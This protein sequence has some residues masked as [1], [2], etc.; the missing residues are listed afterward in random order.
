MTILRITQT[1]SLRNAGPEFEDEEEE[2]EGQEVTTSTKVNQNSKHFTF[3]RNLLSELTLTMFCFWLQ[4]VKTTRAKPIKQ[5]EFVYEDEV[6]EE[7]VE[8]GVSSTVSL[9]TGNARN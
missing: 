1:S 3:E 4:T 9:E 2:D 5:T 6:V 7:E 8:D